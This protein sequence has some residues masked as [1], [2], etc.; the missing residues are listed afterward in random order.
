MENREKDIFLRRKVDKFLSE[1]KSNPNHKPLIISGARQIGK[2][3]SIK[4]FGK[5]YASFIEINFLTMPEYKTIF[6]ANYQVNDIIKEITLINPKLK[7]IPNN[8]L[9]LFDEIQEFPDAMTSLKPFALDKRFDV[10]CSGSLLGIHYKRINSIPVGFKEDFQMHSLD[11]EEYLWA[12]G[13]SEEQIEDIYTYLINLKPL[14]VAYKEKLSSLYRDYI[15][16]GG[17]PEVVKQ[18]V[19]NGTFNEPFKIQNRIYRDYEDDI[20]KYAEGLD[21]TKIKNI[22][23]HINSQLAKDNHKFQISKIEKGLKSRDYVGVDEWLIDAGIINIAH[24]LNQLAIPLDNYEIPNNY[25]IYYSDHSLFISKLDEESKKDLIINSNLEIYN[26]ALYESLVSEALIKSGFD[27]LYFY[28]NDDNTCEIDFVVRIKNEIIPIEVKKERGKSK[29]LNA[30]LNDKKLNIKHGI[31][32]T[33]GNI[34]YTNNIITI[35]YYLSFFLK[36]FLNETKL[37]KWK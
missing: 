10:I 7:I 12:L 31:K 1:W 17:M 29:S 18:F 30:I 15:F 25:R 2:T 8:T 4:E 28:K 33:N 27:R 21:K 23:R 35:P 34:G 14:P 13:Y 11:F 6:S 16:L 37:I 24:N 9:I 3:S 19:I 22:Y 5:T 26:G 32:L 20:T 36:R